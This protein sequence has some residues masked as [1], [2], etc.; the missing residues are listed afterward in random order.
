M[1]RC[2]AGNPAVTQPKMHCAGTQPGLRDGHLFSLFLMLPLAYVTSAL[3]L[4]NWY[5]SQVKPPAC[6]LTL[7]L[8][9]RALL[10]LS[11]CMWTF[12]MREWCTPQLVFRL[13]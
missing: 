8:R 10:Q 3:L 9:T 11:P 5:P 6:D 12:C 2:S 1:A 13:K 7:R 4:F